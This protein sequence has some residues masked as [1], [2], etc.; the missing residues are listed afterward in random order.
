M[1]QA[2]AGLR[3]AERAGQPI[4]GVQVGDVQV[5]KVE[6]LLKRAVVVKA[7]AIQLMA[8]NL[9]AKQG[10]LQGLMSRFYLA[11]RFDGAA[12]EQF[13][14]DS[15]Q[16][17]WRGFDR[18]SYSGQLAEAQ[19]LFEEVL[20]LD[21]AHTEAL[22]QLADLFMVL[23]PDDT[24][25]EERILARAHALLQHPRT[26]DERFMQAQAML[27]SAMVIQLK[28][29]ATPPGPELLAAARLFQSAVAEARD[30]FAKLGRTMWAG[31]ADGML[32]ASQA[33]VALW[34]GQPAPGAPAPPPRIPGCAAWRL[35]AALRAGAGVSARRPV[36]GQHD[37]GH[38]AGGHRVSHAR[39]GLEFAGRLL[40][41]GSVVQ[42][43]WD[44]SPLNNVLLMQGYTNGTFPFSW[45]IQLVNA[46]YAAAFGVDAT[47]GTYQ[48]Y[49]SA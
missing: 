6:L 20:A 45:Q 18:A 32:Q 1:A 34:A 17:I 16:V 27:L 2:L 21:E 36:D 7:E 26:D 40:A 46:Q 4:D 33:A 11:G 49:R 44:F 29:R 12:I 9:T 28:H 13:Q 43:R 31:W 19:A 5:S 25:D 42:G 48:F 24:R 35:A 47:G 3:A 14:S 23:T 38:G 37:D 41:R 39:A 10:E 22:L 30:Q 8:E 15:E